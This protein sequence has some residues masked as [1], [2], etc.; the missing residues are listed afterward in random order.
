MRTL[1]S[2]FVSQQEQTPPLPQPDPL[3]EVQRLVQEIIDVDEAAEDPPESALH[4]QIPGLPLTIQ[5]PEEPDWEACEDVL[6]TAPPV[7]T[8]RN[9]STDDDSIIRINE[10]NNNESTASDSKTNSHYGHTSPLWRRPRWR[11]LACHGRRY[12]R[13]LC[14]ENWRPAKGC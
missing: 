6:A 13:T 14:F 12:R 4:R 3:T 11:S 10:W 1:L 5:E 2:N 9:D 8:V 7:T